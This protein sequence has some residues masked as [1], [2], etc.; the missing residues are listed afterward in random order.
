MAYESIAKKFRQATHTAVHVA[1]DHTRS[2][3]AEVNDEQTGLWDLGLWDTA[4]WGGD[5][6]GQWDVTKWD[7]CFWGEPVSQQARYDM[8][9]WDK[10]VWAE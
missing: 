1:D 7:Q 3:G 5:Q 2:I 6:V 8:S 10:D 4:L 9:H